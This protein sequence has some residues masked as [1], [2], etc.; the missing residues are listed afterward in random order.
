MGDQFSWSRHF[1]FFTCLADPDLLFDV[2][3]AGQE[4]QNERV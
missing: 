3:S 4:V 1:D 2:H